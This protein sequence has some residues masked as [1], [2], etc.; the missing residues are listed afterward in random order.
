MNVRQAFDDLAQQP[1]NLVVVLVEAFVN[2]VPE[3]V[4]LAVLHLNVQ[5]LD[6]FTVCARLACGHR[7]GRAFVGILRLWI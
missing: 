1:P 7:P 2:E 3:R 4:F 5:V 6:A